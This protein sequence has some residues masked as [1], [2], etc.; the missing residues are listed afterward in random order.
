MK[1]KSKLKWDTERGQE[2]EMFIFK[3]SM[4]SF[5]YKN[6]VQT[7]FLKCWEPTDPLNS[8]GDLSTQVGNQATFL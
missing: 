6:L 7:D 5:C 3:C 1:K 2:G 4:A 8:S